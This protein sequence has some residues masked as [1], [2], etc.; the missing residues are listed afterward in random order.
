M[1]H[2]NPDIL[3]FLADLAKNNSREWFADNRAR[4]DAA[5]AD[6]I[7]FI[8]VLLM[9]IE[10]FDPSV[11]GL[12]PRKCVFRIYR[13]IRF[14]HNKA[15]YKHNFGARIQ[16]GGAT[17]LHQRAGYYMNVE[18]GRCFLAGGAFRPT[19]EW[20]GAIRRRIDTDAD[21]LKKILRAKKFRANFEGI[22]GEAVKTA[23]RGYAKDHP[24]IEFLR[25]KSFIVRHRMDDA[26]MFTPGFLE[27][28]TAV[29]RSMRP[30]DDFLNS[31]GGPP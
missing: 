15:P 19:P 17:N 13:D 28:A 5:R 6:F 2:L 18:P 9:E 31:A 1:A 11:A 23:P 20:L 10:D 26:R 21:P 12:D 27:H 4:Y 29:Y 16:Q 24:D 3:G 7:S 30:F 25:R 14:S 8:G 22:E